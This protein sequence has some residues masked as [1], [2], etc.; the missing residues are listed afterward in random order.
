MEL[1]WYVLL[2]T[3]AFPLA[4][5]TVWYNPKVFGNV[6]M[7]SAGM[8]KEQISSG[9]M[10]VIF[11][12][13]YLF[14]LF[15]SSCLFGMVIHQFGT[16]QTLEG[17]EGFGIPGSDIQNYF[18]NFLAQHGDSHRSFNHGVIHGGSA[19][20]TFAL[21]IIAIVALFERKNWSYIWVHFGYWFLTLILMGGAM[22]S[23]L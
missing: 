21:P 7:R 3:A 4:V 9:N 18:D 1:N 23:L 15:L 20:V 17:I 5:G 2:I 16:V 10:L 19:A 12:L 11:G 13:T 22:G 8:T 14:G 6:W